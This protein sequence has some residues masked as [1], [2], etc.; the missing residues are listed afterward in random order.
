MRPPAASTP[1]PVDAPQ[2][3]PIPGA[4]T[5]IR[6]AAYYRTADGTRIVCWQD[7]HQPRADPWDV[8]WNQPPPMHPIEPPAVARFTYSPAEPR[9][10]EPVEFDAAASSPPELIDRYVWQVPLDS[11]QREGKV[12]TATLA[13]GA[14]FAYLTVFTV[15]GRQHAA[16]QQLNVSPA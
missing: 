2:L 9:A 7:R 11:E 6:W 8:V 14:H 13:A 15:D 10:G 4:T 3:P 1:P 5:F 12:I 16:V